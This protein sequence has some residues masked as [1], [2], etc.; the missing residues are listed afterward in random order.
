MESSITPKLAILEMM[1]LIEETVLHIDFNRSSK[2]ESDGETWEHL[3]Q[4][5]KVEPFRAHQS[6][7]KD[8]SWTHTCLCYRKLL[9]DATV[10]AR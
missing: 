1:Q 7:L 6:D 3:A 5:N 8:C 9:S 2:M 10:A 4:K